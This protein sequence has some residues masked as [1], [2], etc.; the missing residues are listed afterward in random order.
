MSWTMS[1]YQSNEICSGALPKI[2][3]P[4][5]RLDLEYFI[6]RIGF[7]ENRAR[8]LLIHKALG[9][10][11]RQICFVIGWLDVI[12]A[13]LLY[14]TQYFISSMTTNYSE[15]VVGVERR[16]YTA[17][18]TNNGIRV[19]GNDEYCWLCR[20]GNTGTGDSLPNCWVIFILYNINKVLPN[21]YYVTS[22]TGIE[23]VYVSR[24]R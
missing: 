2:P 14:Y 6:S 8:V 20:T 3:R 16:R 5:A 7:T 15:N 17:P 10:L 21:K 18:T 4:E 12:I 22:I 19:R 11:G 9:H 13:T 1:R 24:L 23:I